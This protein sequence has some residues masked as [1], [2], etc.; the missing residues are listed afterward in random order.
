MELFKLLANPAF[1]K[2]LHKLREDLANAGV[3]VDPEVC[4]R[5]H[6]HFNRSHYARIIQ[7]AMEM[8]D[9]F[10]NQDTKLK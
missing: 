7:N 3:N 4:H 9:A 2:S 1:R 8:L 6:T 5:F 10:K